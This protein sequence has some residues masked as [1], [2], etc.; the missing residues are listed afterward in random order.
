MTSDVQQ[1]QEDIAFIRGFLGGNAQAP[2][3]VGY[4]YLLAGIVAGLYAVRQFLLDLG[5]Q[6]P[7]LYSLATA[8]GASLV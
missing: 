2:V 8:L 4:F 3:A 7:I 5:W 6:L 1:A